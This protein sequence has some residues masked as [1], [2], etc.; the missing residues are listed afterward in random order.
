MILEQ[1]ECWQYEVPLT[2][3]LVTAKGCINSRQGLIIV[4]RSND[5]R[6]A[7]GEI[8]PLPGYSQETLVEA[9]A[10]LLKLRDFLRGCPIPSTLSSLERLIE[11][12]EK[13]ITCL[14]SVI[15]GLET[16]LFDL[17][18]QQESCSLS[19]WYYAQAGTHVPV[20]G[21]L[22]GSL[23]SVVEQ[24]NRK[25]NNYAAFKLKIGTDAPEL[26]LQKIAAIR[27]M[28][29]D[30]VTIRLDAN[31]SLHFEQAALLLHAAKKYN[32]E[33]VE[34]PLKKE[35]RG[36]LAELRST[37]GVPIALDEGASLDIFNISPHDLPFDVLLI[38]PTIIGGIAKSISLSRKAAQYGIKTVI[39]ST[40]ESGIGITAVLHV[41]AILRQNILPCG[42]D[43][44]DL[45][46]NPLVENWPPMSGG[47][48]PVPQKP[49]L[50]V[51]PSLL[52]PFCVK[53]W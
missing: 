8:A 15:F 33:F 53:V 40:L 13:D 30:H 12:I 35:E 48:M 25:K 41:A 38:K 49:G 2:T 39:S 3:P 20:N 6:V 1:L 10:S 23:A 43:T 9:R 7:H 51:A 19:H 44:L 42:L 14:P 52:H 28:N 18:S 27:Q 31:G 36:R 5:E 50:G 21:L 22:S 26:E 24:L 16:M 37:C 32:L 34:D 11:A 29:G 47:Q 17:A 4:G 46:A 45:L